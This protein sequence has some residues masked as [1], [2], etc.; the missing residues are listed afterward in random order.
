MYI[1]FYKTPQIW[2]SLA[3]PTVKYS[4]PEQDLDKEREVL[5][6]ESWKNQTHKVRGPK[7]SSRYGMLP[8]L[9]CPSIYSEGQ[10]TN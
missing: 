6:F 1:C 9:I 8:N 7:E 2:K 3:P 5:I 4:Q 10:T